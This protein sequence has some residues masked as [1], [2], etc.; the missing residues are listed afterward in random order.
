[1]RWF[2]LVS[3]SDAEA[4]E[5]LDRD[6]LVAWLWERTS[7]CRADCVAV[8]EHVWVGRL[9]HMPAWGMLALPGRFP[10]TLAFP[11]ER[12]D[13]RPELRFSRVALR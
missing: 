3:E 12:D 8:A 6:G 10:R 9:V 5:V 2:T 1:M 13:W 4:V 11:S 7:W